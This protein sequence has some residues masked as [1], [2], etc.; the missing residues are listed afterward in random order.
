M[1]YRSRGYLPETL[2]AYLTTIGG[3]CR[4]NIV[5]DD[6]FY[7]EHAR[8]HENLV[9]N[10][11]EHKIS[12]RAVKLNIELLENMNRRFLKSMASDEKRRDG[13]VNELRQILMYFV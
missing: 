2:L 3:G 10:F 4:A 5:D 11:D 12:N 6:S 8:V 7:Q 9:A 1:W 13:L